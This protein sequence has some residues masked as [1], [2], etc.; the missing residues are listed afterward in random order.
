[1]AEFKIS[2]VCTVTDPRERQKRWSQAFRLLLDL[3]LPERP[4]EQEQSH[5]SVE[6]LDVDIPTAERE[7]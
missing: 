6:R 4:A 3:P 1:M 2:A 5:R 7:W